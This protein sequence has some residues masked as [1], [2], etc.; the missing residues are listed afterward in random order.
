[1]IEAFGL[2]W[3]SYIVPEVATFYKYLLLSKYIVLFIDEYYDYD[4]HGGG[5]ED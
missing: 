3:T 1:V 2:M 4:S 5:G